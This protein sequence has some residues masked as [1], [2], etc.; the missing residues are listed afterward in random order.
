MISVI[1]ALRPLPGRT[2]KLLAVE[3]YLCTGE[4]EFKDLILHPLTCRAGM[5]VIRY[6]RTAAW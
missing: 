6:G 5:P 4:D 1:V 3:L 2:Q